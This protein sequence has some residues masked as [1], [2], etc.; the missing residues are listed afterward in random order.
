M[1]YMHREM[2][3]GKPQAYRFTAHTNPEAPEM[4][5]LF[6]RHAEGIMLPPDAVVTP[7]PLDDPLSDLSGILLGDSYYEFL[8]S[9][10]KNIDG[11]V[12]DDVP[13]IIPFKAKA[14]LNLTA[15]RATE[16]V[17][18]MMGEKIENGVRKENILKHPRDILELVGL[19]GGDAR[20]DL[21]LEIRS[22]MEEFLDRIAADTKYAA[23]IL[24]WQRS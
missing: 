18:R 9:G 3:S 1:G 16:D 8:V 6:S 13:Y 23:N 10:R 4:I 2:A 5:E 24:M 20:V 15:E 21:P 12:V 19:L 7:I 17:R 11:A 14:W 22:D